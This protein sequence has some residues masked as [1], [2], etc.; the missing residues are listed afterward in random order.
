MTQPSTLPSTSTAPGV[1]R[2]AVPAGVAALIA[3]LASLGV[4]LDATVEKALVFVAT[5]ILSG[6]YYLAVR[7][8][9]KRWPWAEHLLG[10][11]KIPLFAPAATRLVIDPD[12]NE[13]V[14]AYVITNVP[15]RRPPQLP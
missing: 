9:A 2:T 11:G 4:E 15:E 13:P 7:K 12:T 8:L 5:M 10:S 3:W 1:I 6:L 14:E